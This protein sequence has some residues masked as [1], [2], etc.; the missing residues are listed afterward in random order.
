LSLIPAL[1][2]TVV[3]LLH[4]PQ[5]FKESGKVLQ[6]TKG[7]MLT[8]ECGLQPQKLTSNNFFN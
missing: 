2:R 4:E 7:F 5:S 6:E 3:I 8:F 1:D